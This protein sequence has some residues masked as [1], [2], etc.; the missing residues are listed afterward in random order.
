MLSRH[1][2]SRRRS[3]DI[4]VNA[5]PDVWS[6]LVVYPGKD[7]ESFIFHRRSRGGEVAW[8]QIKFNELS[9][10]ASVFV[11][12]CQPEAVGRNI[13]ADDFVPTPARDDKVRAA[14]N[15]W[16]DALHETYKH[17]VA[18]DAWRKAKAKEKEAFATYLAAKEAQQ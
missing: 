6:I 2:V 4:R 14:N 9:S 5:A 3:E 11:S 16:V 17:P 15:A 7:V 8:T 10:R 13:L 12:A 1:S 18:S